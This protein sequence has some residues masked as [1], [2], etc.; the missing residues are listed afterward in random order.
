[1]SYQA[2]PSDTDRMP[3]GIPFIVVNEAAERFSY[4]GMKAILVVYMTKYLTDINGNPD[5]MGDAEARANFHLFG[6]AAYLLPIIGA[7]L[8]DVFWGKYKTII[9]LSVVYCLGHLALALGDTGLGSALGIS[10][11]TWL[12]IGLA[13]IAVGTGGIKPCVSAHVGDQFG[14]SN[15]HLLER[16]FGWFYF[17]INLGAWASQLLIPVLLESYGPSVAFGLPGLL[18]GFATLV[19]WLGRNRFVHVPAGGQQFVKETFSKE[20][21]LVM[22]RLSL[23]YLPVALFWSLFDQTSSAW[24]QQ[25]EHLDRNVLGWEVLPAQVQ[26]VN[27]L[28]IMAFVPLFSYVVYPALRRVMKLTP[29]RKMALGMFLTVPSFLLS[30]LIEQWLSQGQ[31]VGVEWQ[32]FAFAIITAAEVLVSITCLEFSYSQAPLKMKSVIMALFL[33]SV[34]LG[35]LFTAIVNLVL[36]D[37]DGNLTVSQTEYYLFFAGVMTVAAAAFLIVAKSYKGRTYIQGVSAPA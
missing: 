31:L 26:S 24:V 28:L 6:T 1:M 16:V 30:A 23:I 8:A 27:P 12:G 22:L 35:N 9:S 15:S 36:Q 14:R 5:F 2:S 13:L 11:R 34:A 19:F 29:L 32:F 21:L 25:A 33:L 18:M 7:V 20:G 37:S 17:S 10:P 3:S 4:Y